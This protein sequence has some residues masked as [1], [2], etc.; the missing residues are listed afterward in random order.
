MNQSQIFLSSALVLTAATL[1]AAYAADVS[2]G[3]GAFGSTSVYRGGDNHVYPL[4][5]LNYESE[6]FYFRGIGGGYY[7]WNDNANRLSL[8]AYY[9]PLGFKP[10][11]SDDARMK[12]L[13]KRRG[14][15]MAGAAYR[16]IADW[17]EI[18][19]VLAGDTLDYSNGIIWDTAYLY[20]FNM[21][22]L[23]II[24]GI[25]ASWFSENMNRYYYGVSSQESARSGFSRYRP[26][27]GWSP[28]VELSANY[29]INSSWSAWATGRY[30]RLSD[31]TKDSPIVDSSYS[32]VMSAG[33]SYR[34]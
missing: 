34:F 22:D 11:D 1:P 7:L 23:N 15:L 6:N 32:A 17:G 19:T 2:L 31:E 26:G 24:P 3:L 20:R 14:T 18:R 16:H 5:V 9:L 27:D 4:P 30:I 21:G 12:Q 29:Q 10:G 33:V 25:G 13:D 28:Y 8:T